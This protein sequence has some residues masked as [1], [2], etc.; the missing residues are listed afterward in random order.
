MTTWLVV[1]ALT[2][3]ASATPSS[4]SV[5]LSA[6]GA[7][8]AEMRAAFRTASWNEEDALLDLLRDRDAEVRR[9]AVRS[10]KAWV[11]QRSSTK[12]RVMDVYRNPNEDLAVRVEAAKTLSA[13]SGN[14]DVQR[15]LLD[16][17]KRGT[18][19]RL[20]AVSYK[21]LYWAVAQRNDVR[22]DVLDAARRESDKTVRLAAIWT[23][24]ATND[25]R[26]KDVL[27]DLARRDSDLDVRVEALKSGWG[28]MGYNDFRDDAYDLARQTTT[29]PAVRKAA[30]L[31]HAN[32]VESR[33]KDLLEDIA[34]RDSDPAARAAAIA[35]LGAARSEEIQN[36][37]HLVRRGHNGVVVYDPL[38]AE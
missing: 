14:W 9:Q 2:A 37:F 31:L 20:R 24:F 23:L 32:R 38:D 1:A 11:W 3:P 8:H 12:D 19:V 22:D 18:D 26:V 16:Y 35:A 27:R 5:F 30:I 13:A 7:A 15:E 17:A 34:R 36:Y 4:D 6:M 28:Y 29:P 21:A 33:Q 10:L 25:N